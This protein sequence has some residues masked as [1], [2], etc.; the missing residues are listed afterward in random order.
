M[1]QIHIYLPPSR[2]NSVL[3]IS[4]HPSP[5]C[6]SLGFENVQDDVARPFLYGRSG[7]G[8]SDQGCCAAGFFGR[9][10]RA[11]SKQDRA[12]V[13]T[14]RIGE[15][16]QARAAR[17]SCEDRDC[18]ASYEDDASG[19]SIDQP[20]DHQEDCERALARRQRQDQPGRVASSAVYHKQR[21]EEKRRQIPPEGKSRGLALP[22]GRRGE[23][24]K[25]IGPLATMQFVGRPD[26]LLGFWLL[27]SAPPLDAR[28]RDTLRRIRRSVFSPLPHIL[29]SGCWLVGFRT[30]IA[31]VYEGHR[32][33]PKGAHP[34]EVR[35][36]EQS[37]SLADDK[38]PS[39]PTP[40]FPNC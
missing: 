32:V 40:H 36:S 24:F 22:T 10:T 15:G 5:L 38:N 31:T 25:V 14:E 23:P 29:S 17:H 37:P 12:G 34:N 21:I 8:D 4:S 16:R 6:R 20:R 1:L 9:R 39:K 13:C 19:K 26:L 2:P 27:G 3:K 11:G 35:V 28:P 30:E 7:A 33:R 18:C